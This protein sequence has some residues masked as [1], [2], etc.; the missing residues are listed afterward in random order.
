MVRWGK[1]R[2]NMIGLRPGRVRW[3]WLWR[4]HDALYVAVGHFRLRLMKPKWM[5]R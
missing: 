5:V 3:T 4:D 2:A 1:E